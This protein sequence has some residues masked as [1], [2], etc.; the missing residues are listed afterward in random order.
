MYG[1]TYAP[2]L[3]M[4]CFRELVAL[5]RDEPMVAPVGKNDFYIDDVLTGAVPSRYK[6]PFSYNKN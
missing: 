1:T 4:K 3:A 5:H 6:R 2:Y